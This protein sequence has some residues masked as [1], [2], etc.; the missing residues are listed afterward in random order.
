MT[1]KL[2]VMAK[3]AFLASAERHSR[4]VLSKDSYKAGYLHRRACY[5]SACQRSAFAKPNAEFFG[6]ALYMMFDLS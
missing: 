3:Q 1:D 6:S 4:A 5:R 2:T